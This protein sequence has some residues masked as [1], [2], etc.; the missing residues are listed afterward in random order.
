MV[1]SSNDPASWRIVMPVA[2]AVYGVKHANVALIIPSVK[3]QLRQLELLL[4][5]GAD[6]AYEI[7]AL[8]EQVRSKPLLQGEP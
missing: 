3:R 5:C 4:F 1:G 7:L 8:S 2:G 6:S